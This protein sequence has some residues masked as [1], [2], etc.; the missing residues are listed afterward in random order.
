VVNLLEGGDAIQS[1]LDKL[2]KWAC[3]NL[4]RFNKAK[5]K[6]LHL[7]WG[8]P[9]YQYTVGDEEIES[10]LDEK[11]LGVPQNEKPDMSQQ[12]AFAAQ[13]ANHTLGCIKRSVVSRLREGILPLYSTLVRP[14][15]ESCIQLWSPQHKKD[16]EL[17]EQVQRK[18][19]K[20]IQALAY[21]PYEERLR[22]LRLFSLEKRRLW[23]DF[24]AVF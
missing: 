19:T 20:M 14:H 11:D 17:L 7:G 12:C 16:M 13:K 23:G 10:S 8:N 5:G 22:E 15:L 6:V 24:I 3:V 1:D 21:L 4:T 9:C 2:K 18:A